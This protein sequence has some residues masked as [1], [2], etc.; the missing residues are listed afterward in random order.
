MTDASQLDVNIRAVCPIFGV[1]MVDPANTATWVI[2]FDPAATDAQK[3]AAQNVIT[4]WA[5]ISA[6]QAAAQAA[7]DSNKATIQNQAQTALTNLRAY[8]AL[9]SPTA[10]QTTAAV[11]LIAKVCV[12]LIR[13]QLAEFDGTT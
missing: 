5:T 3:Q 13:L 4:N 10:A 6:Q 8:I 11:Q 12:G 9:T 2:D 7:L 1:S